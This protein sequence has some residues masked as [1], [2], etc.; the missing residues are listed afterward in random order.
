MNRNQENR[1][2]CFKKC[3]EKKGLSICGDCDGKWEELESKEQ[4]EFDSADDENSDDDLDDEKLLREMSLTVYK[5]HPKHMFKYY[6]SR[7][8]KDKDS[9][10]QY[11]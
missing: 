10:L 1:N 9:E 6:Y 11:L 3:F 2:F 5:N 4:L 7:I 8:Y